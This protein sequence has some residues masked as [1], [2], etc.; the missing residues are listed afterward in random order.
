MPVQPKVKLF[1]WRACKAILP[2]QTNLFDKGVSQTY[3][4]LWCGDEAETVGHLL[5]GCEFAQRVWKASPAMIPPSYRVNMPFREFISGCIDDLGSSALEITFTTAWA[6]WKAQNDLIWNAKNSTVSEIFQY[7]AELAVDFLETRKQCEIPLVSSLS[8]QRWLPPA[9]SNYKLNFSWRVGSACS[10]TG[11]GVLIRDSLGLVMAAKCASFSGDGSLLQ[12]HAKAVLLALEF[13][14]S[15]GMRRL[16]VDVGNQELLGLV[17]LASPSLAPIG[18]L[19][20]D[21][22]NWF[23]SFHFIRFSFIS[24]NCNQ[25]TYVLAT[26]ALSSNSE[27]VWMEDYPACITSF[28]QID[29]MQ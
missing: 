29:S 2:T 13:A 7:A 22:R 21:I 10:K 11:L 27:Q 17:S 14:F 12:I 18:V 1:I 4:C 28:V 26:E 6:L 5:W 8:I 24:K 19:V 9:V 16:E 25:A 23:P 15:I 20:D 3:S